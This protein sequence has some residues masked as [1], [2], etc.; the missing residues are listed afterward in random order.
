MAKNPKQRKKADIEKL[1]GPSPVRALSIGLV[2]GIVVG[3]AIGYI[4][5]QSTEVQYDMIEHF[6]GCVEWSY[7]HTIDPSNGSYHTT[8][9]GDLSEA[10]VQDARDACGE[11]F[12]IAYIALWSGPGDDTGYDARTWMYYTDGIVPPFSISAWADP[13]PPEGTQFDGMVVKVTG[14]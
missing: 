6:P 8:W 4:S 9:H 2:I 5:G 7:N 13:P 1:S 3:A 12:N 10:C 14:C 11:T